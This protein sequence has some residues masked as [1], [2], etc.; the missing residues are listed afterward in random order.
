MSKG[1]EA[2]GNSVTRKWRG[3][4]CWSKESP[5][6]VGAQCSWHSGALS[7]CYLTD[8]RGVCQKVI[9]CIGT[10]LVQTGG[11]AVMITAGRSPSLTGCACQIL[12][13]PPQL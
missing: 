3:Q 4:Q 2:R 12:P 9:M 5:G 6:A 10:N 1:P 13:P 8:L 7:P 11:P